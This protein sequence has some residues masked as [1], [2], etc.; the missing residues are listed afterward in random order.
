MKLNKDQIV[1]LYNVIDFDREIESVE[2]DHYNFFIQTDK[3]EEVHY[4]S[5]LTTDFILEGI[6]LERV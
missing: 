1:R 5:P 4:F 3:G 6:K 2:Y